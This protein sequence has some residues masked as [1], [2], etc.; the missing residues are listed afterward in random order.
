MVIRT[1]IL[2]V[3]EI[4]GLAGRAVRSLLQQ[5]TAGCVVVLERGIAGQRYLVE[6]CLRNW[7]DEEELDLIL[8]IGGAYPAPG[9]SADEIVPEAT[10]SVIERQLPGL[11][12][13]MRAVAQ[14]ET[15]LALLDRGVAGIRG[16][17]LIINLP[18]GEQS[19][20][21]FLDSVIDLLGPVILHLQR[22]SLAPRIEDEL[23]QNDGDYLDEQ[24][25][26]DAEKPLTGLD[27]DEFA[28]FLNRRDEDGSSQ[29]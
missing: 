5:S 10:Q 6:E 7:S 27:A 4:D 14:E 11:A 19:A 13:T 17:T 29:A 2:H 22:S 21:L 18:A 16:R 1:G 12:E 28:A 23:A 9:P 20:V 15:I 24:A 8:T 25:P 26:S 3:P